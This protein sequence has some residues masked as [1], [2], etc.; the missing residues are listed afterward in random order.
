[1]PANYSRLT[2]ARDYWQRARVTHELSLL[3][4][5]PVYACRQLRSASLASAWPWQLAEILE[6]LPEIGPGL[7]QIVAHVDGPVIGSLII[8]DVEGS[9]N[10]GP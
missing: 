10:G 6:M 2:L 3:L 8:L 7:T 4:G 5:K 9:G 1:M